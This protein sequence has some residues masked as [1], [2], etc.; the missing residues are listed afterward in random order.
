MS[1]KSFPP[2]YLYVSISPTPPAPSPIMGRG[3]GSAA[4]GH[5]AYWHSPLFAPRIFATA[6]ST[7][8]AMDNTCATRWIAWRMFCTAHASPSMDIP[9]IPHPIS[10]CC[11]KPRPGNLVRI[12]SSASLGTATVVIGT[13]RPCVTP[14]NCLESTT[15]TQPEGVLPPPGSKRS[16][17]AFTESR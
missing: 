6:S 10:E 5:A 15:H 13:A 4:A 11:Y 14:F 17:K 3:C 7:I 9:N 12:L 8:A 1:T 2:A 16:Y